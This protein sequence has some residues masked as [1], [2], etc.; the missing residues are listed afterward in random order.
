MIVFDYTQQT[1]RR[2][3]EVVFRSH[4]HRRVKARE[5][6]MAGLVRLVAHRSHCSLMAPL[7]LCHPSPSSHRPSWTGHPSVPFLGHQ[8][9]IPVEEGEECLAIPRG[10]VCL[11]NRLFHPVADNRLGPLVRQTA[12]VRA[13]RRRID[14]GDLTDLSV[15][16][17]HHRRHLRVV[18]DCHIR[19]APHR[20]P[21]SLLVPSDSVLTAA[22]LPVDSHIV[23]SRPQMGVR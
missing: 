22:V 1:G 7:H 20:W 12:H 5:V 4:H 11:R 15:A 10:A 19:L 3:D 8:R 17:V 16:S 14:F 23:R 6:G 9:H 2:R 13:R 18:G 21:S